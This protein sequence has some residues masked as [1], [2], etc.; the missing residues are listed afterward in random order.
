M[1]RY[2]KEYA[3]PVALLLVMLIQ[4]SAASPTQSAAFDETY[5]ITFGYAYLRTGDARLSQGQNPPLTNVITALPLLLRTDI[6]FPD[7]HSTWADGNIFSFANEFLW[8]ANDDPQQLILLARLPEMML[9]LLLACVVYAF[10]RSLFGQRAAVFALSLCVFD[11]NVLAHGHIVGTDLGVAFFMFSALWL[12]VAALKRM[13]LKRAAMA[14]LLVGAALATKYSAV[15][16][17]PPLILIG[18]IYPTARST[19]LSHLKLLLIAGVAALITIWMTFGFS[20]N[21]I[22]PGE[23]PVPAAQYWQSLS[24]VA[25]RVESST[26]AFLLGQISPTGF[27]Q[28]YPIVFLLKTPLPTLAFLVLG[29]LSLLARRRRADIASWLVPL[30]FML[31]AMIAGLN[32]G[33]R[34]ILPVLPFVLMIAGRGVEVLL[35]GRLT[36]QNQI[37]PIS[38]ARPV[39]RWRSLL[40]GLLGTW[41]MIDALTVA[42]S[43]IAYF[44]QLAGDRSRDYELLVDSNLDWGQDLIALR[45]WLKTNKVDSIYLAYFGT[46][47]PTAYNVPAQL[48][49]SF[50]LNDH[51]REIDGFNAHALKPGWY[52]ISATSLQLGVL[53]T[54]QNIYA[55]FRVRPPDARAGRSLLLYHIAYPS[56]EIDR[57]VMLGP[58][59]PDLDRT[60][61]GGQ[62]D[63]QLV[64]KWAGPDAAVLAMQGQARYITSGNAL[65][66]GFAP[67]VHDA[68]LAQSRSLDNDPEDRL[69]IFEIDAAVALRDKINVLQQ[70]QVAAPD[71]TPLHLPI[72]FEG[73][74]SLLGYDLIA[75]Q[76]ASIELVT[77]WRI[78]QAQ[79]KRLKT[80][81][82]VLDR[83]GQTIVQGNGMNVS[84]TS[85]EPGDVVIQRLSVDCPAGARAL[86]VG[87]YDPGTGQRQPAVDHYNH[88]VLSLIP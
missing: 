17:I 61:V 56:S 23:I 6:S 72:S 85:L 5:H 64:V 48:L 28:Y 78:D 60:T 66:V 1:K 76:G 88:V 87:L 39:P 55:P 47:H 62:P 63:R 26:S 46:A 18:L 40:T 16:L 75:E 53:Y 19:W 58:P 11:P 52:A 38:M 65:L 84:W 37:T 10:T 29:V 20:L 7:D 30:F 35:C 82:D 36:T 13:S 12:W 49:A 42:P 57:T 27:W 73:G 67:D 81:V 43:H 41:L 31:M 68:L 15:W 34:L 71:G 54:R 2:L 25:N 50:P 44:N 32:L 69:R 22:N 45:D 8:Q 21:P 3:I 79:Q 4:L 24:K 59:A 70:R 86:H 14:G 33:Y 77:Y 51:G 74:F 80:F 9:A 83:A